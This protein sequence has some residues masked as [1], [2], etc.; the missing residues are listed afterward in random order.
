MNGHLAC[1]RPISWKTVEE[2]VLKLSSL[3]HQPQGPCHHRGHANKNERTK[4]LFLFLG[5]WPINHT[6]IVEQVM[7]CLNSK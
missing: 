3:R 7:Y 1:L 4:F 2:A 5:A 6:F